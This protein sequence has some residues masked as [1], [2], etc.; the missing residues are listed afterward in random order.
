MKKTFTNGDGTTGVLFLVT[1]DGEL[2][3]SDLYSIYHKRWGIEVFHKSVK[4]NTSLSKSP[5]SKQMAQ[6]NHIFCSF[7]AY[8]KLERIK[9]TEKKNHFHLKRDIQILMLKSCREQ[10]KDRFSMAA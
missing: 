9:N 8:L 2:S 7:Y 1:N 10:Y 5:A 4:N 3:G 6:K